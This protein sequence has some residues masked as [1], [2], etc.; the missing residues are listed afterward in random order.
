MAL[1]EPRDDDDSRVR[2]DHLSGGW[3]AAAHP[4][5]AEDPATALG[6]FNP[7]L[8]GTIEMLYEFEEP[9]IV[10]HARFARA[11][12]DHATP[13]EAIGRTVRWYGD[14]RPTAG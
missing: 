3:Q 5:G 2:A 6:L 10:E 12:G 13:R 14:E 1:A 11:F 8:R 7:A 4:G 9:F